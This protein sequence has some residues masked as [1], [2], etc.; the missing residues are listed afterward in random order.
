MKQHRI[1]NGLLAEEIKGMHGLQ[2]RSLAYIWSKC[3]AAAD[4]KPPHTVE[5]VCRVISYATPLLFKRQLVQ[6][7]ANRGNWRF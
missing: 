6:G 4:W 1:V 7:E 3:R 2:V 5:D